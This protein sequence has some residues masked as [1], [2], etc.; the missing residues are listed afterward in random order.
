MKTL[1][2]NGSP[3]KRFCASSYFLFLQR[4]FVGGDKVTEHLRTRGDYQRILDQLPGADAVVFGVPLY[5][6]GIPSH[7]MGFMEEMERSCREKGL[8]PRVYAIANNGF[9]EGKQN[10]P[11][12]QLMENFC[13]RAGLTWGGGVGIGGGVMLNVTRI[14]YFVQV[15]MLVLNLL[16][17]GISTGDFLPVGPLQS[18]LKNVLWLLYLNLGVL[19]YLIRMGRAVRKREE[20][21][22]RY[23][24][25]LVPSFIFILFADVFFIILSFLEGGMFRGWLAKKV[26]DR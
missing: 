17:N 9:I 21:G 10:E 16:F 3:K 8:H 7:V 20:A 11:L 6:D 4:L 2:I 26:P 5:V 22:K 25:I 1:F 14:L 23:T 15:G 19:F 24:R 18:F 12:M 13:R